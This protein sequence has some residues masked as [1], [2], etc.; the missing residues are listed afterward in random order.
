[1]FYVIFGL[2]R[3]EDS[4]WITLDFVLMLF[5]LT[6]TFGVDY[7]DGTAHRDVIHS[8]VICL[9]VI[10]FVFNFTVFS[11]RKLYLFAK[12]RVA[13][14][15]IGPFLDAPNQCVTDREDRYF[16]LLHS[17]KH[18]HTIKPR[19]R[20]P[21]IDWMSL[22]SEKEPF[23]RNESEEKREES[24]QEHEWHH[25]TNTAICWKEQWE[26]HRS[27]QRTKRNITNQLHSGHKREN[28]AWTVVI[29]Y[30]VLLAVSYIY[31]Y[32]W[33]F[34]IWIYLTF[35]NGEEQKDKGINVVTPHYLFVWIIGGCYCLLL[36][37]AVI[38]VSR[39]IYKRSIK[40]N[41]PRITIF[42][43]SLERT[44]TRNM[45]IDAQTVFDQ[46]HI[47]GTVLESKCLEFE[48]ALIVLTFLYTDSEPDDR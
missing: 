2:S 8:V 32:F 10:Y 26:Y 25:A 9:F 12:K 23:I 3:I 5:M 13:D 21:A 31:P 46:L 41:A 1:M 35:E 17:I 40:I 4:Q 42:E 28:R 11:K 15:Q 47:V 29:I 38:I 44:V 18:R 22:Q 30:S 20:L 24:K 34:Y 27:D 19:A 7:D 39:M 33:Y 14:S 37:N 36:G 45:V 16:C 48:T 43:W 6:I